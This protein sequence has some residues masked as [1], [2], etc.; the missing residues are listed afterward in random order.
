MGRKNRC[1]YLQKGRERAERQGAVQHAAAAVPDDQGRGKCRHRL[2]RRVEDG[3]VEDRFDVGVAVPPIDLVEATEVERLASEE[4]HRRHAGDVLLQEGVDSRDPPAHDPVGVA[5]VPAE[6]LG[7]QDEHRQDDE[8]RERQPPVHLE[9]DHHDPDEREDVFEDGDHARG[10]Q[11][12][13][14]VDV[15]GHARH[16][17]SHGVPIVV[18]HV[19]PLEVLVQRH[20]Q[21]E[22]DL[23]PGQLHDP[24]LDV[25]GAEGAD[26]NHGVRER[27]PAEPVEL[28]GHHV[29]VDG[30]L[31]QVGLRERRARRHQDRREGDGHLR[32]VRR[33]VAQQ[34]PH[35]AGVVRLAQYVVVVAHDAASSSSSSC[36]R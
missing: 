26:E 34:P 11:V 10:E 36:L 5:H 8:R 20:A 32:T 30:E 15:G 33:Q 16:Q 28:P 9:H 6:P 23:L 13:D 4:L 35:E 3:V 25:L 27:Q 18:A 24:G 14:D 22:H 2:D 1:E 19:E 17:P 29:I 12:V 21:I 7:D 31:D